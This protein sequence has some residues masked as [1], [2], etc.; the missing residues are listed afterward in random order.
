MCI[1][2]ALPATAQEAPAPSRESLWELLVDAMASLERLEG[3]LPELAAPSDSVCANLSVAAAEA[4]L[5]TA[6]ADARARDFGLGLEAGVRGDFA[7]DPADEGFPGAYVGLSWEVLQ[8]GLFENRK[9]TDLYRIR[10]EAA[11]LE[12]QVE[13]LRE[14]NRCRAL[15]GSLAFAP[16]ARTLLDQK[17]EAV[18][19][20]TD[21]YREAYLSGFGDLESVLAAEQEAARTESE[22]ASLD[23]LRRLELDSLATVRAFPPAVDLDIQALL[24]RHGATGPQYD[25]VQLREQEIRL[26]RR[27]DSRTRL[28]LYMRYGVRPRDNGP[29]ANGFVGGVVFRMPLFQGNNAGVEAEIEAARRR[30]GFDT[31]GRREA[32]LSA[33]ARFRDRLSTSIRRHYAYLESYERVR[34]S[35]ARW[36]VEP[37]GADLAEALDR[38]VALHNAALDR[39]LAL[40]DLYG[41]ASEVFVAAQ[42]PFDVSLLRPMDLPDTGY[43]ARSG[44]RSLYVWSSAFNQYANEYLIELARAKGFSRLAVSAGRAAQADKLARFRDA[45]DDAGIRVE[46]TLSTNAWLTPEGRDAVGERISGLDT[47]GVDVHLDV[48]P[49]MLDSFRE[50][51]DS[52][53]EAWLDVVARAREALD[54]SSALTVSVPVWWPTEIYARAAESADLLYLMAYEE[55]DA[56]VVARRVQPIA[57]TVPADR[58]VLALRAQDFETEWDMDLVFAHVA[59]STGIRA[60]AVHD[61]SRF[62]TLIGDGR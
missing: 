59:A 6:R 14:A 25:L 37:E 26:Q 55:P 56:T 16:L 3:P 23:A 31:D 24:A 42:Q 53:L 62:M 40:R 12:S 45:A 15:A 21:A 10:S 38:L 8:S 47:E 44:G 33:H 5:Y 17:A 13:E 61:L 22:I 43:R 18:G 51:P 48:E 50:N 34:R 60:G 30:T 29:D 2:C 27:V 41:A 39:S 7:D 57:D 35:V 20:L 9:L 46:L 19:L 58:L 1:L 4:D 54:P 49:Q 36:R 32:M 11:M 28:R 52:L